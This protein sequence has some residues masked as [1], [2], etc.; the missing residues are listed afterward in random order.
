MNSRILD[1]KKFTI[2]STIYL[3]IVGLINFSGYLLVASQQLPLH[4]DEAYLFWLK[5][6]D[7]HRMLINILSSAA[8][9]I[10]ILLVIIYVIS[11]SK[12]KLA[13]RTINLP[14]AFSLIG[15]VGWLVSFFMELG[16]LITLHVQYGINSHSIAITSLL[17]IVQSCIFISTLSFMLLDAIHRVYVL[18]RFFPGG[19]LTSYPGSRKI[20]TSAIITIFYLSAGIFPVFYLVSTFRNYSLNYGFS[21]EPSV[22]FMT[23]GIIFLSILLLVACSHYFTKPLIKLKKATEEITKE[24][25]KQNIDVISCDD[26]GDL[27]DNFNSMSHSLDE[28]NKRIYEIQNSI[29]KGMAIMVESRD[30]STGGHI[31]RTSDC[32]KVF[33]DKMK[34]QSGCPFS[35]SFCESMIKAAPMHDLGK[36][37]IDDVILRKPGKFTDEEFAVMKQHAEKGAVIVAEVLSA[38]D[39]EEFK[40]IAVN[41]AHYHH[42]RWDGSGYPTHIKATDIPIEA[43]IM[44]LADV[45]DALVSKRCYKDSMSFDKAFGIITE[46]LGTHFDPELGQKFLECRPELEALYN[47]Y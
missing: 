23:L 10:P 8:F 11:T 2:I 35:D 1:K 25:F 20:S 28:K 27:A 13:T 5:Y 31:T 39:D 33:M 32:V 14:L 43:R 38:S 42:E 30:N 9:I 46:S 12:Q 6:M 34:E 37:A 16:I 4:Q 41:V 18:P 21:I 40:K 19:K 17:N 29:I 45:F 22:Y 7:E 26:F 36:I 24:N 15:G 3:N 44:A 47:S